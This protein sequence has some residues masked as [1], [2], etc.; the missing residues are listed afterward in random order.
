[1]WSPGWWNDLVDEGTAPDPRFTFANE[2]TFLAWIRTSLAL[3]A[4]GLGV[5]A[6]AHDLPAWSR[7]VL[8]SVLVIVG[9]LLGATAFARWHRAELALRRNEPRPLSRSPQ[10][11]SFT[12]AAVALGVTLLIFAGY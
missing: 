2:R 11:V 9:G 7:T 8:A 12:L 10:I 3:I 5:D 6:F 1:M 4:G